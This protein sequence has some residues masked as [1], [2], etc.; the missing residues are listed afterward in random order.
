MRV[1]TST[2]PHSIRLVGAR[3][4]V[5]FAME[6]SSKKPRIEGEEDAGLAAPDAPTDIE[7]DQIPRDVFSG[8]WDLPFGLRRAMRAV[9][10]AGGDNPPFA[11]SVSF[12][13]DADW[14]SLRK[15]YK[16]RVKA[17]ARS[18]PPG[19][20]PVVSLTDIDAKE[21]ILVFRDTIP[22]EF[23]AY[24]HAGAFKS[25]CHLR[26]E[27]PGPISS[28]VSYSGFRTAFAKIC[29]RLE[30]L[31]IGYEAPRFADAIRS[32]SNAHEDPNTPRLFSF[33]ALKHLRATIYALALLVRKSQ[34]PWKSFTYLSLIFH[35]QLPY[36]TAHAEV[37][38]RLWDLMP[39]LVHLHC[40]VIGPLEQFIP[41]L[42][43]PKTVLSFHLTHQH[44]VETDTVN[45]IEWLEGPSGA[46]TRL[47]CLSINRTSNKDVTLR[48]LNP[49]KW[50]NLRKLRLLV[51]DRWAYPLKNS[52]VSFPGLFSGL[53]RMDVV[54]FLLPAAQGWGGQEFLMGF[55]LDHWAVKPK[56][57]VFQYDGDELAQYARAIVLQNIETLPP[58]QARAITPEEIETL[59]RT[60]ATRLEMEAT[61]RL[62]EK[63]QIEV[64][65]VDAA[66]MAPFPRD[67][68]WNDLQE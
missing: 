66:S 51:R 64:V 67:T 65:L 63:Y 27:D 31:D 53:P 44:P 16:R 24:I 48:P 10:R 30:T 15:L 38:P 35:V 50:P 33:S 20:T 57:A 47:R 54:V 39:S 34:S 59:V 28:A 6:P 37:L 21:V 8:S 18:T 13:T 12:G 4:F 43:L 62:K 61:R 49:A 5:P 58:A 41:M 19:K 40:H 42:V 56:T 9:N 52:T 36:E 45:L 55:G 11:S 32:E 29:P 7:F 60:Q 25:L 2:A 23:A 1:V 3:T 14:Y 46:S 22:S 68:Y 17:A 26:F